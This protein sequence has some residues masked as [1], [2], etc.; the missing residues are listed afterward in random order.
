MYQ[1]TVVLIQ[2]CGHFGGALSCSGSRIVAHSQLMQH[3]IYT[4]TVGTSNT[5]LCSYER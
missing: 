5:T 1:E 3:H 4:G 2:T